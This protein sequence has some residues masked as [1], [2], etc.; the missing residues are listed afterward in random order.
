LEDDEFLA[1]LTV[2]APQLRARRAGLGGLRI[3]AIGI[4]G[5]ILLAGIVWVALPRMADFAASVIPVSW[6]EALG[7]RVFDDITGAFASL[8]DEAPRFCE[9]APG[10]A[11]LDRLAAR[12]AAAAGTAYRYRVFVLDV[13]MPNAFA[14]P[15]GWVVLFRG[16]IDSAEDSGEVAG[17]LAHEM[18][19]VAR[20]HGTQNILRALGLEVL[21]DLMLGDMGDGLAG[22]LGQ[23][24]VY[25][26]YSREA[27]A[28]AD[29]AAL[30]LLA[31]AGIG[32][33]GLARFFERLAETGRDMPAALKLLS[34]HPSHDARARLFAAA[35]GTGGPAMSEADWTALRGICGG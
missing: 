14:L 7:E 3:A 27:E 8:D 25:L 34:T 9:A 10:R 33:E 12:L 30:A 1:E 26:S 18:G 21:F 32:A 23:V 29:T 24:L 19:H 28:E 4:A 17:V 5:I 13:K 6:E 2:R 20:R 11:A 35:A 15:G 31:A 16:L 22:G